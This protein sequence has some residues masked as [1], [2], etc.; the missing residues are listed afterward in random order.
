VSM[1][2]LVFSM[3]VAP[4]GALLGLVVTRNYSDE[5]NETDVL[6]A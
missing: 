3:M 1:P 5:E 6:E 2:V 4:L